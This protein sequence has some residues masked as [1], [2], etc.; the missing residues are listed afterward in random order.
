[1]EATQLIPETWQLLGP[2]LCAENKRLGVVHQP[3]SSNSAR[4]PIRCHRM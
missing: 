4:S 2:L 3:S 1:V